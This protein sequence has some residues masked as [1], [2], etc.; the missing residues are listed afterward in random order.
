MWGARSSVPSVRGTQL[1]HIDLVTEGLAPSSHSRWGF[2][3]R[4]L[5]AASPA[6]SRGLSVF[7][8]LPRLLPLPGVCWCCSPCTHCWY[9]EKAAPMLGKKSPRTGL[10]PPQLWALPLPDLPLAWV[11]KHKVMHICLV[12][13]PPPRPWPGLVAWAVTSGISFPGTWRGL[14]R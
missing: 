14:A 6:F 9:Q 13:C 7:L 12:H 3:L 8:H 1:H 2:P 4:P 5:Q 11:W 10:V